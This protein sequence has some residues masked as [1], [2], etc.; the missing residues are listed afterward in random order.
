MLGSYIGEILF[1]SALKLRAILSLD[2]TALRRPGDLLAPFVFTVWM[3]ELCLV[4][5][6]AGACAD[7]LCVT[8]H[9]GSVAGT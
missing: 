2:K 1:N 3:L 4:A 7:R 9:H 5:W 6:F 8:S